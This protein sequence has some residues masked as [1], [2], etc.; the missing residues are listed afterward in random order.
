MPSIQFEA[1]TTHIHRHTHTFRA[2]IVN[3]TSVL[4]NAVCQTTMKGLYVS[5]G[6]NASRWAQN[7][8]LEPN[9]PKVE[10]IIPAQK[11]TGIVGF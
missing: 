10:R 11:A 8:S 5:H 7:T 9:N 3:T 6:L 2:I 1:H 4:V